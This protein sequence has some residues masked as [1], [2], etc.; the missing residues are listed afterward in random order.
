MAGTPGGGG[1]GGG[2]DEPG[3]WVVSRVVSFPGTGGA[4]GIAGGG[5]VSKASFEDAPRRGGAAGG[6]GGFGSVSG[7]SGTP[8]FRL[9]PVGSGGGAS[10]S[11]GAG[12]G[13]STRFDFCT[14]GGGGGTGR[15]V[16]SSRGGGGGGT[17]VRS[18][19][20]PLGRAAPTSGFTVGR[21][22]AV[23]VSPKPVADP[24]EGSPAPGAV[25]PLGGVFQDGGGGWCAPTPAGGGHA[26]PPPQHWP[27]GRQPTRAAPNTHRPARP[28]KGFLPIGDPLSPESPSP[29]GRMNR[30]PSRAQPP[31]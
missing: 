2:S 3:G 10:T 23:L 1:G 14:T 6:G 4:D 11:T 26:L 20:E 22:G 25:V 12:P 24:P 5:G 31:R 9:T 18:N 29:A 15:A 16:S 21:D 13:N 27:F 28:I 7:N 19:V 8:P 30:R 17:E